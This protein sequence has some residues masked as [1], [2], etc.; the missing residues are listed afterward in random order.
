MVILFL[1]SRP[2]TRTLERHQV[3]ATIPRTRTLERRQ[4]RATIPRTRTLERR[5]VRATSPRTWTLERHQVRATVPR[6]RT[7]EQH[8]VRATSSAAL[9]FFGV[10]RPAAKLLLYP[11]GSIRRILRIRPPCRTRNQPETTDSLWVTRNWVCLVILLP[12]W[13]AASDER[14]SNGP[15]M[16]RVYS[17]TL[18]LADPRR[19]WRQ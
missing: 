18:Y 6:T 4:V 14:C 12:R 9:L 13:F 7:L 15:R 19:P 11:A 16:L 10:S 17:I 2:P 5:Q 1:G 8:Q 3:P